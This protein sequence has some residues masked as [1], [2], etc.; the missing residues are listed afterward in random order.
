MQ[1][2]ISL[3]RSIGE[4]VDWRLCVGSLKI[5]SWIIDRSEDSIVSGEAITGQVLNFSG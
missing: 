5:E 2:G 1:W 4:S 3:S